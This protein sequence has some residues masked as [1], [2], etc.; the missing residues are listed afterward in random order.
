M[1]FLY[2]S[3]QKNYSGITD[4]DDKSYIFINSFKERKG[5]IFIK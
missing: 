1:D 2:T 3:T 4:K 5:S